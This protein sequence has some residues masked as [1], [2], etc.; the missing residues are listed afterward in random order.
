MRPT[1]EMGR[2]GIGMALAEVGR[3]ELA[4][5]GEGV[6]QELLTS[7]FGPRTG[8]AHLLHAR[9]GAPQRVHF[10]ERSS[11]PS[12]ATRRYDASNGFGT[13]PGLANSA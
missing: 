9:K 3:Q 10:G 2:E 12:E 7:Q 6:L 13:H 8:L 11:G 4:C 5:R 1:T